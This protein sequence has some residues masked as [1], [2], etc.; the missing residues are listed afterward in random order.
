VKRGE[1]WWAELGVP[2][3]SEP[4]FRRP[5]LVVSDDAFNRSK[6]ATVIGVALT[7]NTRLAG[8]PGNVAVPQGVGGLSRESVVNVTQVVTLDRDHLAT[9]IGRLPDD[10]L[11]EVD[12]GLRLV[13]GI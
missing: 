12:A 9:R 5:F 2:G 10:L 7:S 1:V 6:L 8:I 13:L 3:G 4:G 11:R